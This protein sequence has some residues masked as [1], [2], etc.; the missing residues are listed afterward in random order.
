MI[1][2]KRYRVYSP[3]NPLDKRHLGESAANMLVQSEL[4]D[5]PV[6]PFIGAGVYAIYYCGDF[7]AYDL[8]SRAN[9]D[10]KFSRPIYIG[11]AIPIGGRKGGL[12]VQE[13]GLVLYRRLNDHAKSINAAANLKLC[14][15]KCRF[16]SV[17]DIWIP[18][19]ENMLIE[20]YKPVWNCLL[21]GFGNHDPGRGRHKGKMSLWDCLHP[22]REWANSLQECSTSPEALIIQVRKYLEAVLT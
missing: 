4:F 12:G 6:E 5:L 14:D 11:K 8:L 21:D 20:R 7:I 10:G 17:D 2:D 19:T 3:F 1:N 16:L 18:L 22:G 15:F 13:P 9:C